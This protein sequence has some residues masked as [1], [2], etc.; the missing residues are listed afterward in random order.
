MHHVHISVLA[1]LVIYF[2]W[3]VIRVPIMLLAYRFHSHP[4]S[5]AIIQFG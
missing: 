2:S 4:L 1:C 5:Q 3:L